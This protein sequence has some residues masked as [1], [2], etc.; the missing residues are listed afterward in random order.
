VVG[1]GA[2]ARTSTFRAN[3][4]AEIPLRIHIERADSH[5]L[6]DLTGSAELELQGP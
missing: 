2:L 6:P 4:V 3:Y 1:L 5:L